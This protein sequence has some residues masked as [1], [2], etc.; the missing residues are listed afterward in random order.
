MARELTKQE[1]DDLLGAYALDALDDDER[2]Q[3]EAYLER[4]PNA[5]TTVEQYREATA[6]LS[7][8]TSEAPLD[9]WHRIEG[10]LDD[11]RPGTGSE[12]IALETR[13]A[14]RHR[15]AYTTLAA[16]AAV[17]VIGFLGVKVVQ[18]D[19]RIDELA[20]E[21]EAGGGGVLAAARTASSDPRAERVELAADDGGLAARIVYLPDGEGFM[22]DDNLTELAPGRTYQLWA[23]VG[24]RDSPQAISAGVLGRDP[25]V[26]A[27]N[28]PGPVVGFAI[29]DEAAPGVASSR[30]SPLLQG[31]VT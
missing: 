5:R 3:V 18:Q 23:L 1:L 4:D 8:P 29:T 6:H 30:N 26:A 31:D 13:R 27:F 9:L 28:V 10:A 19:D 7:Q 25:G 14:R 21:V 15:R 16:A 22:V 24:D 2:E 12:A 17:L 20:G 11:R